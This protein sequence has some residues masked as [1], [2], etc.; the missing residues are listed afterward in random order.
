[1]STRTPSRASAPSPFRPTVA[2]TAAPTPTGA[3]RMTIATSRNMTSLRLSQNDSMTARAAP[4]TWDS[5]IAK[6]MV[7][8][9]TGSD[10]LPAA[11]S[12]TLRGTLCSS[13]TAKP[14]AGGGAARLAPA[15][16]PAA[17]LTPMPGRTR[18]TASRPTTSASV[19]TTSK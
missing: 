4:L 7:N 6:A 1:V 13:T 19:V 9:T 14:G 15:A 17:K 10:S 3:N 18:F 16:A 12:N 11:A 2:A 5:A 8:T